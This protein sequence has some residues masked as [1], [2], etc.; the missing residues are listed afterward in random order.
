[1]KIAVQ[2]FFV[3]VSVIALTAV[4]GGLRIVVVPSTSL[5]MAPGTV[6]VFEAPKFRYIDSPYAMCRREAASSKDCE[7]IA[8]RDLAKNVI[9]RFPFSSAL[10]EFTGAPV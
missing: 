7:E 9:L 2:V 6:V 4:I 3:I 5:A 1:M 10:Y 8:I